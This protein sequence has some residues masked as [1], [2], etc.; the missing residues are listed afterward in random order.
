MSFTFTQYTKE[1]VQELKNAV[2]EAKQ[3]QKVSFHKTEAQKKLL[4]ASK[5][6]YLFEGLKPNEILEVTKNLKMIDCK[7]DEIIYAKNKKN[8]H[9][10]FLLNGK[11]KIDLSPQSI[12]IKP[13]EVFGELM[14]LTQEKFNF[15]V[16]S[17]SETA[18][19]LKFD[20][21]EDANCCLLNMIYANIAYKL[22]N[23]YKKKATQTIKL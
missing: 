15:N 20:I 17:V 14:F 7:K 2:K 5:Y 23:N 6:I 21:N 12:P 9:I 4:E 13:L 11:L 16:V 22:A 1:E 19:V 18:T 10:F 3:K 8:E